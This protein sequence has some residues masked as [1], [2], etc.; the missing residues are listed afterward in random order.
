MSTLKIPT[1]VKKTGFNPAK[2]HLYIY[3][4]KHNICCKT[5]VLTFLL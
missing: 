3:K 1:M 4:N 2:K 5:D